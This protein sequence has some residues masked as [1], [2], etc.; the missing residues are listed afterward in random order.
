M[1]PRGRAFSSF[2]VAH[3]RPPRSARRSAVSEEIEMVQQDYWQAHGGSPPENY[4]RYL[5]P[6]LFGPWAADLLELAA[7][8]PGERVLDVACGT[9]AVA[10]LAEPRVGPAGRAV[11]LD[12]NPGM[13]AVARAVS[14]EGGCVA[15][16]EAGADAMPFPAAAFDLVLCQMGLQFFP[17]RPAAL[18]EMQRVLVPGGRLALSVTGPLEQSPPFAIMAEALGRHIGPEAAGFVRA[19]FSLGSPELLRELIAGVGFS[20][21]TIRPIAAMLSLPPAEEF[22]RQYV[23]GTPLAAPVGRAGD[24][25]RAALADEFATRCRPYAGDDGMAL[26][27]VVQVATALR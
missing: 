21:V 19:V 25:A 12:I 27:I 9:G 15:W 20:E 2:A 10:R 6:A 22:L 24:H 4:E 17:D 3:V 14:P 8:R 7:P 16:Q 1:S 13:L 11:G 26:P 23:A 5:V 18:R